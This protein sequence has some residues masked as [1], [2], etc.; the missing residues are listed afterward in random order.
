[1][2]ESDGARCSVFQSGDGAAVLTLNGNKSSAIVVEVL[3]KDGKQLY[4]QVDAADDTYRFENSERGSKIRIKA[5]GKVVEEN[6]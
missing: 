6:L 1:M 3:S 2:R 5:N 4:Q